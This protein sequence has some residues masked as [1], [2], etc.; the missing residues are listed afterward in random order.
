[1]LCYFASKSP[2]T[3][4]MQGFVRAYSTKDTYKLKGTCVWLD[5]KVSSS[6]AVLICFESS[7][8]SQKCH[9]YNMCVNDIYVHIK[10]VIIIN[11]NKKKK[12]S[13]V[14]F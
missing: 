4:L 10:I 9:I 7:F 2:E 3:Q 8:Y 12:D 5:V 11:N 14:L 13:L 1:M 6:M